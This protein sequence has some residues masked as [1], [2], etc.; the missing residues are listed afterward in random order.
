MDLATLQARLS[1]LLALRYGG[2][3]EIETRTLDAMERVRFRS[4]SE[5]RNAIADCE[6]RIQSLQGSR[7]SVV[8][9]SPSKGL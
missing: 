7:N 3:A 4:D 8:L 6:R 9:I 5:L 2:E 1:D